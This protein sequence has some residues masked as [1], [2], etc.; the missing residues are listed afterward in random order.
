[1]KNLIIKDRND[2]EEKLNIAFKIWEKN[3]F[4]KEFIE[5]LEYR[6]SPS[7]EVYEFIGLLKAKKEL[8]E[9]EFKI[10]KEEIFV[11][12]EKDKKFIKDM[13]LFIGESIK[14][15]NDSHEIKKEFICP[16]CGGIAISEKY[17]YKGA[18]HGRSHCTKCGVKTII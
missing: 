9:E 16:L 8:N 2:F 4:S 1:M 3:N 18:F 11:K 5:R 14:V 13:L 6:W 7:T 17:K 10:K 12:F 15:Y